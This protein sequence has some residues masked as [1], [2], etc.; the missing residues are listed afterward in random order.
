M[1]YEISREDKKILRELAKKQLEYANMPENVKRREEWYLHNDLKGERPMIHLETAT[2]EQEI[3]P[4]RMRCGG[5]FARQVEKQLYG[6]FLNQ[7][8][9]YKRQGTD[10]DAAQFRNGEDFF[11][12]N[13]RRG[14]IGAEKHI[15][16]P[17]HGAERKKRSLSS[18]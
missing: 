17:G 7:E 12:G 1:G 2:F 15:E 14:G 11:E 5:A 4:D 16:L 3:L 18:S 9:V 8:D 6:N 10:I 13:L